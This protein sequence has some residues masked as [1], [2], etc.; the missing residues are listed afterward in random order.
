[1]KDPWLA[2]FPIQLFGAAMGLFGLTLAL[3]AGAQVWPAL[4]LPWL[5]ALLLASATLIALLLIYGAKALK[6]PA[7][8][9]AEWH[10][11]IKLAFFPAIAIS[12]LLLARA[13]AKVSPG[14]AFVAFGIGVI[15]QGILSLAVISN[16]I[17]ARAFAP[18]QMNPAWF[19]P[20]VGN[21]VVPL[22]GTL[23][24]FYE[25]SWLF[26]SV[27]MLFWLILLT[28]VFN[29]L[30]F[31]D[32]LPGKLLPTLVILIAPPAIGFLSWSLLTGGLDPMGRVLFYIALFFLALVSI[33][34]P[35]L[36]RVP[37]AVSFWALSFPLAAITT[38]TFRYAEL[39]GFG[40]LLYVGFGVL[41]ALVILIAGLLWQ[42]IR[43][44]FS[45][46]LLQPD[47]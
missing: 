19:I 33:E 35:K 47:G 34:L 21:V 24:G 31:H 46:E 44:L 42:T 8:V 41:G 18:A 11:P 17:S 5:G 1:M 45:R 14:I 9:R 12:L 4:V 28:L 25:I 23:F 38:A 26:F 3:H 2:H 36:L 29:R 16:W 40:G 15:L 32:P 13:M 7:Q 27:G 10:H 43:G 39:S 22:A 20:A 30:I 6:H 37:F